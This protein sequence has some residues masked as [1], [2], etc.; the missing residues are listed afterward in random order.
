MYIFARSSVI[1]RVSR[2]FDENAAR[3]FNFF[4]TSLS[5][6][7]IMK[8]SGFTIFVFSFFFIG[9]LSAQRNFHLQVG[10]NM[11][12]SRLYHNT[13][14]R[15]SNLEDLYYTIEETHKDKGGYSWEQFEEDFGLRQAYNQPR[16]GFSGTLSYRN[17]PVCVIGELMSSPSSYTKKAYSVTV[18]LGKNFDLG[19][20]GFYITGLGG[21]QFLKD[22]GFGAQTLV[23]SIGDDK[24]RGLVSGYFAPEKPL[25]TQ[26]AQMFTIKAGIGKMFG[27]DDQLQVG[28]ETFGALDLTDRNARQSQSRM[29][30]VGIQAYARFQFDFGLTRYDDRFYPSPNGK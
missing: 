2:Y 1:I 6:L 28:V 17:W 5:T 8:L 4:T 10:M 19:D 16:F 13:N 12:A 15:T 14:F 24:L 20:T 30:N 27:M 21:Y 9:N 22:F 3:N 26:A 7:P 29:T 23:N 11:G 18:A 25:G